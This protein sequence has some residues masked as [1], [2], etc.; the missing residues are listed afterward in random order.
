MFSNH[1]KKKNGFLTRV[2]YSFFLFVI[3]LF[4]LSTT[5]SN[6]NADDNKNINVLILSGKNNHKWQQTTPA[7][8]NILE[9]SG[10]FN[11]TVTNDPENLDPKELEKYD[12]ILSNWNT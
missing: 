11:V 5:V 6:I 7:I 12:V 10:K 1:L 3:T 2:Y 9:R 8:Q 4:M